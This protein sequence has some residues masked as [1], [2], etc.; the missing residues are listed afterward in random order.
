MTEKCFVVVELRT[1]FTRRKFDG[2]RSRLRAHGSTNDACIVAAVLCAV[3]GAL[4]SQLTQDFAAIEQIVHK[5]QSYGC[6]VK[7]IRNG[8]LD[9]LS[10]RNG[11]EAYLCLRYGEAKITF[12]HELHIG[13]NGGQPL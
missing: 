10:L 5:I 3:G 13:L 9:F 8:L 4:P 1:C 6:V 2:R 12:Y 7:E 11:R